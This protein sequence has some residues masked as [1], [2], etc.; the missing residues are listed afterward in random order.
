[1]N[2]ELEFAGKSGVRYVKF[3]EI[4]GRPGRFGT[5][6]AGKSQEGVDAAIKVIRVDHSSFSRWYSD[7]A[8]AERELEVAFQLRQLENDH[9]IPIVDS[10]DVGDELFLVMPRAEKSLAD[11]SCLP[12]SDSQVISIIGDVARGLEQLA[13]AGV[14]HRDIKPANVLLRDGRWCLADFGDRKSVV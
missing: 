3:N 4:I 9:L 2:G 7:R 14:V 13:T 10:A 6:Y 12:M 5:V 1:M 8:L 11:V